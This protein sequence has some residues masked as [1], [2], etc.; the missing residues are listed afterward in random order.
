MEREKEPGEVLCCHKSC[1]TR[2][3]YQQNF[4][5]RVRSFFLLFSSKKKDNFSVLGRVFTF[6]GFK[7]NKRIILILKRENSINTISCIHKPEIL[8]AT[9]VT[10]STEFIPRFI[11]QPR[12]IWVFQL[13]KSKRLM[14]ILQEHCSTRKTT[15]E[16]CWVKKNNGDE[17]MPKDKTSFSNER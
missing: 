1:A 4:F 9:Q 7:K 8:E 11:W 6:H 10:H 2:A 15:E 12:R 16:K 14:K 17:S 3:Y 5:C 13:K